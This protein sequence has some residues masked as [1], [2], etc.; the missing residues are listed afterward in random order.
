[1]PRIEWYFDFISPYAYLALADVERLAGV[2]VR[3]RPILFAALLNHWAHKGPAE[4]PTKRVWTYRW[5]TWLAA[6]R[7]IPFQ[8]P[9]AHPFNSLAYLR[10][11]IA[12]DCRP[13]AVRRIFDALWTTGADPSDANM[14]AD[15]ARSLEVDP[16]SLSSSDIKEKLRSQTADAIAKGL[17]GVPTLLI[18]G[19]L[20]WG[21]DAMDFAKAYIADA[22]ILETSEMKRVA[23]L[24]VGASRNA[25]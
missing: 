10:L 20:F 13:D 14:F 2:Q 25:G 22:S 12:C 1:M 3:Y 15:L 23:T 24:P 16:A 11:A 5:C 6:Q 4:I 8:F 17:F 9:A 19:E 7:D 21:A 18:G